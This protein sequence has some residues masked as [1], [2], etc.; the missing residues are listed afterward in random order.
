[1][2]KCSAYIL[3]LLFLFGMQIYAAEQETILLKQWAYELGKAPKEVSFFYQNLKEGMFSARVTD[4]VK[5]PDDELTLE[6]QTANETTK[7]SHAKTV[8]FNFD[9]EHKAGSRL[10][11]E[12]M[13]KGSAAGKLSVT[14]IQSEKPWGILG[15]TA[16]KSLQINT[17]CQK[18]ILKF[19]ASKD[20]NEK[21]RIPMVMLEHYP[22]GEKLYIGPMRLSMITKMLPMTIGMEWKVFTNVNLANPLNTYTEI[23]VELPSKT[24]IAQSLTVQNDHGVIDLGVLTSQVIIKTSS[25]LFN[26]F[27]SDQDGMMQIG[28]AADWWF[29][30]IVNGKVVYDTLAT[31]NGQQTYLPKDHVFNFPV[32][33]GNN[34]IIV[35]VL[36]G[37][38]VWKFVFGSVPFQANIRNRILEIKR[39]KQWRPVKM[40]LVKWENITPKLIDQFKI[41]PGSALVLSQQS[42]AYNV[43]QMGRRI[44]SDNGK[45]VF[46][47]APDKAVKLRGLNFILKAWTTNFNKMSHMELE[48]FAEQIGLNGMNVIRYHFLAT[49]LCGN[50]GLP[51]QGKDRKPISEVPIA[52]TFENLP[53]DKAFL[54]RFDFFNKCC[55]EK[56][57]YLLLDILTNGDTGWTTATNTVPMREDFR[58]GLLVSDQYRKNW[59]SGFDFL[60]RHVNPYTGK[61]MVEDPQYIGITFLNEHE[62]LFS[63]KELNAFTPEWQ[64]FR[65]PSNPNSVPAFNRKLLLAK[66]QEGAV[67]R[68]YLLNAV[69]QLNR[70]YFDAAQETGFKGL[71]TNWDMFMHNLEG[72][73]R[74][75]MSAVCMHTYFAYPRRAKYFPIDY[76]QRLTCGKWLKGKMYLLHSG[77]S[78]DSQNRYLGRSASTRVFGKPFLMTEMS[79]VGCNQYSHET[80]LMQG[81]YAALQGW[82]SMMPH[83]NMIS[84]YYDPMRTHGFDYASNPMAKLSSLLTAF[85]WQ[86]GDIAEAD[87][88]IYFSVSQDVTRSSDLHG[89]IGIRYNFLFMLNKIGSSYDGVSRREA[90]NIPVDS[91]TG[92]KSMGIHVVLNEERHEQEQILSSMDNRLKASGYLSSGNITDVHAGVFQSDT[93]Q[94]IS[95][96]KKHTMSVTTSRFEGAIQKESVPVKLD[97]LEIVSN[98]TPCSISAISLNRSESLKDSMHVLLV[99]ATM[100]AAESTLV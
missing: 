32:K 92:S 77:S 23:P 12:F 13:V 70:F 58:Y 96:V 54:D 56:G 64:K 51:K 60:M 84:L 42:T 21:T 24:G 55:R 20:W 37:S 74:R 44:V 71:L 53:I 25:V 6:N 5:T 62:H 52:T 4:Q 29:E 28:C 14:C 35:N 1:M 39:G 91:F 40:G 100:F 67:A 75:N 65:N 8:S 90:L 97:A 16:G 27:E 99:I 82:D 68:D 69:E 45:L 33:K 38:A 73:A 72:Y 88:A 15:K 7:F 59:K 66:S 86:R 95:N 80:G 50:S 61:C 46:E 41:V 48:E 89:A 9:G 18:V 11:V 57:I 47:N 81:V 19:I 93:R 17:K 10:R 94:I 2:T 31:G 43:D 3:S 34:I 87:H 30:F 79:H 36:S 83:S 78:I 85:L 63:E 49:A 76:Q 26:T 98:S 22:K